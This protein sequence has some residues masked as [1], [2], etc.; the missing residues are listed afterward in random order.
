MTSSARDMRDGQ[1][2][3]GAS[4]SEVIAW[5]PFTYL[6][7]RPFLPASNHPPV[8]TYCDRFPLARSPFRST[9]LVKERITSSTTGFSNFL[10]FS[11]LAI[12]F[13]AQ[14]PQAGRR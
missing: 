4:P 8:V 6:I 7:S 3:E 11:T 12:V 1:R 5:S 2:F 14:V 13:V 10:L 9:Q